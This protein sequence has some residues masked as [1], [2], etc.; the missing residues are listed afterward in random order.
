MPIHWR[1]GSFGEF[2]CLYIE[3]SHL[4]GSLEFINEY[5]RINYYPG[6]ADEDTTFREELFRSAVTEFLN[7][8]I[9]E[10]FWVPESR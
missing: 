2:L 8:T 5:L 3:T 1:H 6:I 7:Q 9:S 10:A 4:N